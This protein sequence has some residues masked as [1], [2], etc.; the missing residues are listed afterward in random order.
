MATKARGSNDNEGY[1][2]CR[3]GS[4]AW[5][6]HH[7]EDHYARE[8]YPHCWACNAPLGCLTCSGIRRE[9]LCTHTGQG[10]PETWHKVSTERALGPVWATKEALHEHGPI[11]KF[12]QTWEDYP[13]A[14][15]R[16]R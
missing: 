13:E 10:R 9:L 4:N 6:A 12:G 11:G 16:G 8:L 1:V 15:R 7:F 14:W 5:G 2:L 3:M